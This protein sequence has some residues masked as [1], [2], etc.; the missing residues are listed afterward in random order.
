[1][2]LAPGRAQ[3][4]H[5]IGGF[6]SNGVSMR[7]AYK[8]DQI[9]SAPFDE[10]RKIVEAGLRSLVGTPPKQTQTALVMAKLTLE[11]GRQGT[12]LLTSCHQGN[13]GNIKAAIDYEGMFTLY[14]CNEIINGELEWFSPSGKLSGKGGS[15]VGPLFLLPPEG[16]GHPQCRFRAYANV[17]DG[18]Y[19]YLDFIWRE[20]YRD[21]RD[22]LLTGNPL[23]YVHELK[24][25]G[26]FTADETV[27][28]KAVASIHAEFVA[29]LAGRPAPVMGVPDITGLLAAQ[30]FNFKAAVSASGIEAAFA[31]RS[32]QILED[33]RRAMLHPDDP[34]P[35]RDAFEDDE[36][37]TAV[38][39]KGQNQA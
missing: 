25:K 38:L 6:W 30:D 39:P 9:T 26:Y 18:I 22:A 8:P 27:Y 13:C 21:A 3:K 7:A 4:L 14:P 36:P 34:P 16:D 1:M 19:E 32:F 12:E 10:V 33:N 35:L 31:N 17:V 20:K 5:E 28:G 37:D 2:A 11:S 29:R 15:V 23:A 24:K